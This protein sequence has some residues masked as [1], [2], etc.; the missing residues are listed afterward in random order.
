MSKKTLRASSIFEQS[1]NI[2]KVLKEILPCPSVVSA[3]RRTD[4]SNKT[5]IKDSYTE[6]KYHDD[7]ARIK[8]RD[9]SEVPMLNVFRV[10]TQSAAATVSPPL[11]RL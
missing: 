4:A 7:T 11:E 10:Y 5:R 9:A 3:R 6:A 2:A 1:I 8:Y